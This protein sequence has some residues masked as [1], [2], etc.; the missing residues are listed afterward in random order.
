MSYGQSFMIFL[1]KHA[2]EGPFC[3][4]VSA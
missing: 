2:P 1:E 3:L 4:A